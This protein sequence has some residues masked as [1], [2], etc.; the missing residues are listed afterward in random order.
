MM[1]ESI[2]ITPTSKRHHLPFNMTINN[3]NNKTKNNMKNDAKNNNYNG[4]R[5][6]QIVTIACIASVL[7]QLFGVLAT[8]T[9]SDHSITTIQ[10]GNE[11]EFTG[12]HLSVPELSSFENDTPKEQQESSILL[13]TPIIDKEN[14]IIIKQ[15]STTV[16]VPSTSSKLRILVGILSADFYNDSVYRK[17]H[18]E[19]FKLWNDP[20]VC[21]LPDFKQRTVVERD[22]CEFIYT[23]VIGAGNETTPT[24]LL[25]DSRPMEVERPIK[26]ITKDLNK[27]DVTLLNIK[28]NMNE[29]KSQTWIKYASEIAEQYNID[30]VAK[31]DAD[32]IFHLHEFFHFAY[33]NMPPSPYNKGMFIGAL[34]DKA[35]WPRHTTD[36]ERV[37]YESYFGKYFEGVHLYIAG[38]IYIMS[39]DVAKFIGKE[40]LDNKCSYC[41]GH[42]DHDIS[43]MAFY[44]P[45]PIKLV[46]IGRHQRFWE[47]P[48]KGEP[49]WKRIW[50]R[51]T[52]R[53]SGIPFEDKLFTKNSTIDIVLGTT[54]ETQ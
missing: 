50:A 23:F 22:V 53:M 41:E 3:N 28:E 40:A 52:A 4:N 54:S 19:L 27:D 2:S 13:L 33:K 38:Q 29:G 46:C 15:P 12:R 42:E 30:Y 16:L 10:Y 39:I 11:N 31:C 49:R 36:E 18:R 20:R 51:E 26:G 32:T 48:V 1:F 44:N 43:T 21:S 6:V 17:R 7:I 8:L 34:R 14:D 5:L 37:R 47:H 25:D 45:E 35:Y 9:F 24:E